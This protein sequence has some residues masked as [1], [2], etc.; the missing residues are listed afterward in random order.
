MHKMS[1]KALE[2]ARELP[3]WLEYSS[4]RHIFATS[5]KF[6]ARNEFRAKHGL[7]RRRPQLSF[8]N[9]ERF[10]AWFLSG[11]GVIEEP[12]HDTD[13][14]VYKLKALK[15]LDNEIFDLLGGES[16]IAVRL[17]EVYFSL[18]QS[19]MTQDYLFYVRDLKGTL[20]AI[21]A[22]GQIDDLNGKVEG[23]FIEAYPL[24]R[25]EGW[26]RRNFT[27]TNRYIFTH[28]PDTSSS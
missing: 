5:E 28:Y 15:V 23:W 27:N 8:T 3:D 13:L 16:E 14:N 17:S 6:I 2:K 25:P 20:R 10:S 22:S 11:S 24:W 18:V 7:F 26:G 4:I 12:M 9:G 19:N 21:S 1:K